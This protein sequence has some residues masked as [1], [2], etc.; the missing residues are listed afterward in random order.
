MAVFLGSIKSENKNLDIEKLKL[1]V[2]KFLNNYGM[3]AKISKGIREIYIEPDTRKTGRLPKGS[4]DGMQIIYEGGIY[5][6]SQYMAG[7]KE[8]ELHI[9]KNT[10]FLKTA[11]EELIKGNDR[12]PIK[13][14]K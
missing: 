9:Y 6:V 14:Y 10:K 13:I 4:L 8:N 2:N 5:E 3:A 7:K 11:L 12:K 1:V